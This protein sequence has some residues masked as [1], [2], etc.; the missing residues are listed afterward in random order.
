MRDYDDQPDYRTQKAPKPAE[1]RA[2]L[3][4]DELR[5]RR[6]AFARVVQDRQT[7]AAVAAEMGVDASQVNQWVEA[8][9]T[10]REQNPRLF[11]ED[12]TSQQARKEQV[13]QALFQRKQSVAQSKH[14]QALAHR[15]RLGLAMKAEVAD[16][17]RRNKSV[18][19]ATLQNPGARAALAMLESDGEVVTLG[20]NADLS[21]RAQWVPLADRKRVLERRRAEDAKDAQSWATRKAARKNQE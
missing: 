4:E 14:E 6:M 7:V 18:S 12:V 3:Y 19:V 1:E 9:R 17:V 13:R 21:L 16:E 20:T 5:P 10:A 15:L 2:A 11:R 8:E